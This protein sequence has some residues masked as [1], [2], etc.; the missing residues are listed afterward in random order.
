MDQKIYR[1]PE[2][3]GQETFYFCESAMDEFLNG[4]RES[5]GDDFEQ[6]ET[7]DWDDTLMAYVSDTFIRDGRKCNDFY[8]VTDWS[9]PSDLTVVWLGNDPE[10]IND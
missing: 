2:T 1:T 10:S 7:L 8:R 3:W 5:F 6:P 4:M 9:D